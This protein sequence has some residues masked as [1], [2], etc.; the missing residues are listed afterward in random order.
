VNIGTVAYEL[1]GQFH[2]FHGC[3][4][5]G[6]AENYL[7][8]FKGI[9]LC[10]PNVTRWVHTAQWHIPYITLNPLILIRDN[11]IEFNHHHID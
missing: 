4:G 5:A 2:A 6:D 10:P 3:N 8:I 11:L 7:S 1:P 9:T